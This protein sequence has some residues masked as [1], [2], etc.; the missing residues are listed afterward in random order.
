MKKG[1]VRHITKFVICFG[2]VSLSPALSPKFFLSFWVPRPK[3]QCPGHV[4]FS[5]QMCA[6][7]FY[8]QITVEAVLLTLGDCRQNCYLTFLN[9][10]GRMGDGWSS[11]GKYIEQFITYKL[12]LFEMSPFCKMCIC[13]ASCSEDSKFPLPHVKL[14]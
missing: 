12:H 6:R 11:M 2:A 10:C 14:F 7:T 1:I 3:T 13:I 4:D 5:T 9:T 8:G